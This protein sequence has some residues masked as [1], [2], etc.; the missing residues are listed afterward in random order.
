MI[1]KIVRS[2]VGTRALAE[3]AAVRIVE[4]I[5]VVT[6]AIVEVVRAEVATLKVT[7]A[8]KVQEETGK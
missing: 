2:M 5:V 8:T 1:Q 7:T 4:A 6:I 3:V